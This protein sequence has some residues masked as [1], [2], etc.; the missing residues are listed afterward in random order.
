LLSLEKQ[1]ELV[2][3]IYW[4]CNKMA[5]PNECPQELA[6]EVWIMGN[7]QEVEESLHWIRIRRD[8]Y[9]IRRKK[10]SKV[11]V[12]NKIRNAKPFSEIGSRFTYK[13]GGFGDKSLKTLENDEIFKKSTSI[14]TP[15]ERIVI[16]GRLVY[17]MSLKEVSVKLGCTKERVRQIQNEA[18]DRIRSQEFIKSI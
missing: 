16:Y 10:I 15:R 17:D 7:V 18:I 3:K 6:S 11:A 12:R 8:I 2:K 9:E 4:L 13:P 14:L 1:D 5:D